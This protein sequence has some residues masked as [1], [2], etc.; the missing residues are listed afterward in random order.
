VATSAAGDARGSRAAVERGM[1][2]AP[3]RFGSPVILGATE[4][5][6]TF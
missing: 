1:R 3:Q 4:L 2:R 5:P 6:A